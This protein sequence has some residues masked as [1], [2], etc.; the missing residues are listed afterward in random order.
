MRH[1][2]N[3]GKREGGQIEA[4]LTIEMQSKLVKFS[5]AYSSSLR[6]LELIIPP[7]QRRLMQWLLADIILGYIAANTFSTIELTYRP[8]E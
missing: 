3:L 8:E 7:F 4:Q 2:V 5:N 6:R 1:K